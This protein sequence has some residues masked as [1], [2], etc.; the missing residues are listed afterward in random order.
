MDAHEIWAAAQLA[1]GEG[2]EDGVARIEKLM[3]KPVAGNWIPVG[4]GLPTMGVTVFAA[5]TE[6]DP[7]PLEYWESGP[8]HAG[9]TGWYAADGAEVKGVTH[10]MPMPT[11]PNLTA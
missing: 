4:R 10:W 6:F 1:P 3:D 9:P 2:I 5:T 11:N 7:E 8:E